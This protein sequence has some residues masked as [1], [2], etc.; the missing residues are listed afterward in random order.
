MK[1][2][3]GKGISTQVSFWLK[4][5]IQM[6]QTVDKS[7]STHSRKIGT[8]LSGLSD[9]YSKWSSAYWLYPSLRAVSMKRQAS[10]LWRILKSSQ[11][12][13]RCTPRSTPRKSQPSL[14]RLYD[15]LSLLLKKKT[16]TNIC[17][18]RVWLWEDSSMT[19]LQVLWCRKPSFFRTKIK[20]N[21]PN[22]SQSVPNAK[23]ALLIRKA[24]KTPYF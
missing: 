18:K 11:A 4:S 24:R 8:Q 2:P 12:K 16:K 20:T 17:I 3:K 14:N 6:S 7:V 13:P 19:F 1:P 23:S 9:I 21:F 22:P 5:S 15:C 10:S